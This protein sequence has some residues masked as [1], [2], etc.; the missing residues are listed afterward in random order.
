MS[1]R[2]PRGRINLIFI[3]L[4]CSV[5]LLP[6]VYGLHLQGTFKT[7]HFFK[8]LAKFGFQKTDL[9]DYNTLGHIFGNITFRSLKESN[10][11]RFGTLLVVDKQHFLEYYGNRSVVDKNLACQRMFK[12]IDK[13]AYDRH[14]NQDGT[15]DFLRSLP[16]PVGRLCED[17]D[18]PKHVVPG[19]QFTYSVHDNYQARFWYVSIV[20]CYRDPM[21]SSCN[22]T[23]SV[24]E[25]E[26]FEYDIWLVNGNPDTPHSNPFEFQFSFD[27][28]DTAEMYLVFFLL[29]LIL[30][31]VQLHGTLKYHHSLTRLFTLSLVLQLLVILFELIHKVIFAVN[32]KGFEF[33][34]IAGN[35]VYLVSQSLFMLLLLLLAKGWAITRPEVTWKWVLFGIWFLYT[36]V[37]V[38]LYIWNMTEVD[39]IEDIDE[40]QTIPGWISLA[41]RLVVMFWFL[42]ELRSTMMDENEQTKLRFYLD[43]GAGIL[44]WF[45]YLPVVALIALNISALWRQKLLL[46][47][48]SGADFLA[49]STMAHLLWPTRSQQYFQLAAEADT[50]DELE[51]FSEAPHNIER[52]IKI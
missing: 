16:C 52:T 41:F 47:I 4:A 30:T 42:Y 43:F 35:V 38:L 15:E 31:A 46:G 50:G 27:E 12:K 39:V 36:C 19:H 10:S 33:M 20:S 8:F 1:L 37:N 14:C 2:S 24:R 7:H 17:E 51:E 22:W 26:E 18:T 23:T 48:T 3:G 29:Y 49:Y 21:D 28:Q 45:I 6:S 34:D 25:D 11:K 40:Y 44:V 9:H 32:G 13:I 5:L